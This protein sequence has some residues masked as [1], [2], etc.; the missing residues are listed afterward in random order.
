[1]TCIE[2][3]PAE[4]APAVSRL[5]FSRRGSNR[6]TRTPYPRFGEPLAPAALAEIL[7]EPCPLGLLG[8]HIWR[9]PRLRDLDSRIWGT[10]PATHCQMLA[11]TVVRKLTKE[12]G[13]LPKTVLFR[14]LA[15]VGTIADL[16]R[17]NIP[18]RTLHC[19]ISLLGSD[20]CLSNLTVCDALR[21][22][23]CGVRTL[24]D[25]LVC[26]EELDASQGPWPCVKMPQHCN[27]AMQ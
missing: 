22:K 4:L 5:E 1:M 11:R 26:L 6:F 9:F 13:R 25:L 15:R 19:L 18:P 12:I 3:L 8:D 2:P 14:P 20:R 23:N 24:V 21:T 17:L 16:E 27:V 7:D 10:L